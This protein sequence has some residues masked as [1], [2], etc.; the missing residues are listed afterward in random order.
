LV[1]SSRWLDSKLGGG[2]LIELNFQNVQSPERHTAEEV[3]LMLYA[4]KLH[5]IFSENQFAFMVKQVE[6]V[7]DACLLISSLD[8]DEG[9]GKIFI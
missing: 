5:G 6:S 2:Q 3:R 1:E 4:R 9:V 7:M 8:I